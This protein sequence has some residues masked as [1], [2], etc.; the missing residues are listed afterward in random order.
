MQTGSGAA[1][2]PRGRVVSSSI[3]WQPIAAATP[4]VLSEVERLLV[5]AA[6]REREIG[7]GRDPD[8]A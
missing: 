6:R 1:L 4:V 5:V 8:R 3:F 2:R 7:V